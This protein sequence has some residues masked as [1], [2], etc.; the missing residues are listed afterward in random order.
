MFIVMILIIIIEFTV[1]KAI[2]FKIISLVLF[3]GALITG[4][5]TYLINPGVTFKENEN[6]QNGKNYYCH[7]CNFTY[8]KNEKTYQHCFACGVCAPDTDHH[9]GVFGK[10]IGHKNKVSFYLFPTFSIILLI[11]CFVSILYHFIH[12]IGKKSENKDKSS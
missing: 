8:P 12:E 1:I 9:C 5:Y 10:C 2:L 4:F 7:Q 3:L 6:N 11:L